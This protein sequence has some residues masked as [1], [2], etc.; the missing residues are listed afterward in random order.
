MDILTQAHNDTLTASLLRRDTPARDLYE[1]D[2]YQWAFHNANLLRQG[3]FTEIDLENII[4]ELEGMA[5]RD[6]RELLSRLKVL[7]MHLL[8]WQYQPNRRSESWSTTIRT[9]RDEIKFLLEDS[10][11]LKYSIEIVIAKGFIAA[12]KD[13]EDE[14]GISA[15]ILPETCIYTFEQLMDRGFWPQ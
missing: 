1:V 3:R 15:N 8:K 12:K 13:F 6:R 14:T 7:I 10:P 11:S 4:E 5:R 9:Q 2:F